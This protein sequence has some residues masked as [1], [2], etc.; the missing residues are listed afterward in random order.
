[1]Q[2]SWRFSHFKIAF[3]IKVKMIPQTLNG[4]CGSGLGW[5]N[6][7]GVWRGRWRRRGGIW[8]Q[9]RSC[10]HSGGVRQIKAVYQRG[11]CCGNNVLFRFLHAD[12]GLLSPSMCLSHTLLLFSQCVL[13]L[14]LCSEMWSE[15]LYQ[16]FSLEWQWRN[17]WIIC[18]IVL[19]V[20]GLSIPP[21]GTLC[22]WLLQSRTWFKALRI[23][24][25]IWL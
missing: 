12:G 7:K 6:F 24:R 17:I 5:I 9:C 8:I 14:L 4:V 10:S 18:E 2:S 3:I 1:M 25:V 22:L 21:E 23:F 19:S 11:R 20:V 13:Y 16:S 15:R